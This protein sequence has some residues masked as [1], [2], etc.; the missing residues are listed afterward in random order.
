MSFCPSVGRSQAKFNLHGTFE[1][2]TLSL[3]MDENDLSDE[4]YNFWVSIY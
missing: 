3:E 4:N 1:V 2:R